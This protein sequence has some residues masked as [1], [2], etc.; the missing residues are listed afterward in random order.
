MLLNVDEELKRFIAE[1]GVDGEF[2]PVAYYDEVG[3]FICVLIKDCSYYEEKI[4]G[5]FTIFKE[6]SMVNSVIGFTIEGAKKCLQAL[7]LPQQGKLKLGDIMKGIMNHHRIK[8]LSPINT[9]CMV[10]AAII[11]DILEK[12]MN[13]EIEM[14]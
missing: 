13:L 8:S 10:N 3:D 4:D 2:E 1:N 5:I 7:C 9:Q 14:P 6:N 12:Y 11:L